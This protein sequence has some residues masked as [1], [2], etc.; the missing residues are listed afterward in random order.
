MPEVA[1]ALARLAQSEDHLFLGRTALVMASTLLKMQNRRFLGATAS[2][3]SIMRR[4]R[5]N[6]SP[7]AGRP[8]DPPPPNDYPL[9]L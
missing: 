4:R 8:P 1:E 2:A 5:C 7:R 6:G 9:Q 3:I